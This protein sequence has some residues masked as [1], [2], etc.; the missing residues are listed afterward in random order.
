MGQPPAAKMD[1]EACAEDLA[2]EVDPAL[3][4]E[5]AEVCDTDVIREEALGPEEGIGEDTLKALE[6]E[7]DDLKDATQELLQSMQAE[8]DAS[9]VASTSAA[10]AEAAQGA[11]AS[12]AQAEEDAEVAVREES[13]EIEDDSND[14]DD[15]D[16][17]DSESDESYAP[18]DGAKDEDD[19][20]SWKE[21]VEVDPD[22][23]GD[24]PYA[25]PSSSSTGAPVDINSLILM[26]DEMALRDLVDRDAKAILQKDRLGRTPLHLALLKAQPDLARFLLSTADREVVGRVLRI[27]FRGATASGRNGGT[28]SLPVLHLALSRAGFSREQEALSVRCVETLME[29]P[30]VPIDCLDNRGR[31]ALHVA[32]MQ[33]GTDVVEALLRHEA[34]PNIA[35]DFGNYPLH[36]AI[37][38]HCPATMELMFRASDRAQF[39]GALHPLYRCIDRQAWAALC[40]AGRYGWPLPDPE[41]L[42]AYA[43]ARG[44]AAEWRLV[45]ERLTQSGLPP[46]VALAL[47]RE[48]RQV[49]TAV[50]THPVC[51]QHGQI[52]DDV[53]D[54]VLRSRLVSA[55]LE[56]PH[57]LEVLC[58]EFGVLRAESF[59]PL[60]R[61]DQARPAPLVDVLRV[62]EYR[63]VRSLMERVGRLDT[64]FQRIPIDSGDT[65]VTRQSW[66][67]ALHAAGC[68]LEAVDLIVSGQA[69]RSFC[70][71]RPPGHHLGP[72]GAT[73]KEELDESP[74]GSQG[75][76]LLN[77]VAIGAAYARCVHRAHFSKVAIVDF[78][79]HHGNGT[80][81]I[82]RG[83]T[84]S[85]TSKPERVLGEVRGVQYSIA[86]AP[87][88]S[89][90]PWLDPSSDPA[91][92][93][94]ASIHGFGEDFYPGTGKECND[95]MPKIV[96][97]AMSDDATSADFRN[98]FRS[99]IL[100]ELYAFDPD[101]LFLSAGFDGHE[102]D[103]IGN[104]HLVDQD[105]AWVTEQMVAVANRCC[106]GRLVSVLEGGYN[107]RAEA[108]SP[109]AHS[110]SAH[111]RTL[112][113]L[114]SDFTVDPEALLTASRADDDDSVVQ[115]RSARI[116]R[117]RKRLSP[118]PSGA[119]ERGAAP[120]VAPQAKA[121]RTAEAEAPEV[122][123]MLATGADAATA[124]LAGADAAMAVLAADTGAEVPPEALP[125]AEAG[126]PEELGVPA[127][128]VADDVVV[129]PTA[130]QEELVFGDPAVTAAAPEAVALL[131][132][133]L[134]GDVPATAVAAEAVAVAAEVAAAAPEAAALLGDVPVAVAPAPVLE[135]GASEV[136]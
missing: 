23:G 45:G 80:E 117:K 87:P 34:D 67:A 103:L 110:V 35:D 127:S 98:G 132:D 29:H 8:Q 20:E 121:G 88:P 49:R 94:F 15:D 57:R 99:K 111:V 134:L 129:G 1:M 7:V 84:G 97:V 96:N 59:A 2:A 33:A 108:V 126:A 37:D 6:E 135:A 41:D 72:A 53:D 109:L 5:E 113:T 26:Q 25:E 4:A 116:A 122:E 74:R 9:V 56:N 11:S 54:P 86:V 125:T 50:L 27:P 77:N 123:P 10:A 90:K 124:V 130:P 118:R 104:C 63:Y 82:V 128:V 64:P 79:V 73:D 106:G 14:E 12:T 89:L 51:L 102:D 16:D 36:Y 40:I 42:G 120:P 68:V 69:L 83:L 62:H 133:A 3:V 61:V 71:V 65:K 66:E 46:D 18:P 93:M 31:S 92:V 76:C 60:L 58:G 115:R 39:T 19:K 22:D 24:A 112:M 101:I 43:A 75:F 52:P 28:D 21:D 17:E 30:E 85:R 13:V 78:D 105:F 131:G 100:P 107:S 119:D 47:L 70:A 114:S 95:S 32:C 48:E 81:A 91:D 44:L 55:T 38:S 136:R